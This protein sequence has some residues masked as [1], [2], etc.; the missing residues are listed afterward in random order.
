MEMLTDGL[1]NL[2]QAVG[3]LFLTPFYYIALLFLWLLY[4]RQM[5]LERRCYHTRL[6]SLA[7][8][9]LAAV[10]AGWAVGLAMSLIFPFIGMQVNGQTL[11][12]LWGTALLLV[13]LRIR[14][15]CLAYA[16]GMLGIIRGVYELLPASWQD[17]HQVHAA[18]G[19]LTDAVAG[20][21]V[22]SLLILAALTHMAEAALIRLQ[23]SRWATP[24]FVEGKRGKIVGAYGIQ[25]FWPVPLFLMV[26][27]GDA[28]G[29]ALPWH[30]LFPAGAESGWT[31]AAF[32]VLIG[33]SELTKTRL[34]EVKTRMTA[35]RLAAYSV[36]L[37]AL[38]LLTLWQQWSLIPAGILAILL[39]E[40]IALLSHREEER[41]PPLFIHDSRGLRVLGI[42]PGSPADKMG[43]RAGEIITA[44]NGRK[45]RSKD[46]LHRAIQTNSAFCKLELLDRRSEPR[47]VQRALYAGQHH[48]LGIILSPDNRTDVYVE[49]LSKPLWSYFKMKM[50]GLRR[51]GSDP[52]PADGVGM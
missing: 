34:A 41:D 1:I 5:Y 48:Q 17:G 15:F 16:A 38:A 26:P 30:T 9:M 10:G 33:F 2:A 23:G 24:L 19:W 52:P 25:G 50:A 11:I 6:H 20:V 32:P 14:Y 12:L 13:W 51:R 43:I 28:G 31:F 22:P 36:F 42:L 45:V 39:H 47:F 21:H 29:I 46:D 35:A 49:F 3:M 7:G 27:A 40:A 37:L 4:R 18:A 8:P 44:A